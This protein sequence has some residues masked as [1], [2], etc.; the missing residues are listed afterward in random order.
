MIRLQFG[1]AELTTDH[2]TFAENSSNNG[3]LLTSPEALPFWSYLSVGKY[4]LTL[5]WRSRG[6]D[7]VVELSDY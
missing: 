1:V 7:H 2:L 5:I 4:F 6:R 3:K